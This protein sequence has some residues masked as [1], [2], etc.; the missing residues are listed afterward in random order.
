M[1]ELTITVRGADYDILADL[2]EVQWRTL[3][4]QASALLEQALQKQRTGVSA[5]DKPRSKPGRRANG[6]DHTVSATG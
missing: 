2:A 5:P 4:C 1:A 6:V 3:E